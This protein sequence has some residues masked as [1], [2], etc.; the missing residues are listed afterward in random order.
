M[1]CINVPVWNSL[2]TSPGVPVPADG[3]DY[4]C[5]FFALRHEVGHLTQPAGDA[6]TM[7]VI[8]LVKD[9]GIALFGGG[10][11]RPKVRARRTK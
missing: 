2:G 3:S 4:R 6:E 1:S 9:I 8:K 5:V 11:P 10:T 7:L